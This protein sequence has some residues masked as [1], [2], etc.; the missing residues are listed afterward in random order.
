MKTPTL[1]AADAA[2]NLILGAL[3]LVFPK[4]VV[5][6]L[7]IPTAAPPFYPSILGGV[8]LGIGIALLIERHRGSGGLG[9]AGA[10]TINLC[11]GL[12]LAGWLLFGS[13]EIPLRGRIFLWALVLIL[14][15]LSSVEFVVRKRHNE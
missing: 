9:L 8:F 4:S 5:S 15:V 13:L 11:G 10:V 3:L 1:L 2:I 12:V 6:A 7:G 14:V